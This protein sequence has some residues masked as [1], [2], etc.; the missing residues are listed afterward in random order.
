M[1]GVDLSASQAA[2][3]RALLGLM[4]RPMDQAF[5]DAEHVGAHA[6]T[7]VS[8]ES[9]GL[10]ERRLGNSS[11]RGGERWGYRLTNRGYNVARRLA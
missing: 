4:S 8:L 10:V 2:A 1:S 9:R 11:L 7:L 3:L 6:S 5:R